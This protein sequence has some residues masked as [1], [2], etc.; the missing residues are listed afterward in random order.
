MKVKNCNLKILMKLTTVY[1][2]F[3]YQDCLFCMLHM[4]NIRESTFYHFKIYTYRHAFL[5]LRLNCMSENF[6]KLKIL[7]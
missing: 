7:N 1:L 2:N 4:N 3:Y 5:R 6:K